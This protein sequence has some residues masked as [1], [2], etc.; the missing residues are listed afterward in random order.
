M[1]VLEV[2][3]EIIKLERSGLNHFDLISKLRNSGVNITKVM[4]GFSVAHDLEMCDLKFMILHGTEK[5]SKEDFN[6]SMSEIISE[7]KADD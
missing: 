6:L 2:A 1:K 5:I 7:Q 4:T 3:N